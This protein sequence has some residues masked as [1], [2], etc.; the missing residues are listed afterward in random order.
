MRLR[1]SD[2]SYQ[3]IDGQLV[4]LDLQSSK[5]LLINGSGAF[6]ASLM[7][8]EQTVDT[9]SAALVDHYDI[10]AGQAHDDVMAFTRELEERHLL[11][12]S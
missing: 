9:L 6:L 3:E 10:D 4:I 1:H 7:A 12:A 2:I 5:Y 8:T 11:E